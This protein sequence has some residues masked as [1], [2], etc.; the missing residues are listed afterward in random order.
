VFFNWR[1]I[2]IVLA[3]LAAV[4]VVCAVDLRCSGE[5]EQRSDLA[6]VKSELVAGKKEFRY[7][8]AEKLAA[9]ARDFRALADKYKANGEMRKAHRAIGTAQELDRKIK[10]LREE[11][12]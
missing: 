7:Q 11:A 4:I 6:R 1:G 2:V 8:E 5:P 10:K 3:V 12:K 9:L